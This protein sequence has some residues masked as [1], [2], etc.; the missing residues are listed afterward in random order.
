MLGYFQ[1][2]GRRIDRKGK[3]TI[4][5]QP[6][7]LGQQISDAN[8][9]SYNGKLLELQSKQLIILHKPIGY[10]C[11]RASQ[12]GVPTI[13]KL[14]PKNLHHLKPV[15]RLDKDSSGL[16]LMTNDGDFCAQHDASVVL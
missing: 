11:S 15:G 9:I 6:A 13:Y 8:K 5:S 7:R 2:E 12:G 1:T 14:L 3:I 4:D 10:L 16:I